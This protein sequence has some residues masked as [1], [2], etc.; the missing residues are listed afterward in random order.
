MSEGLDNKI[1][2]NVLIQLQEARKEIAKELEMKGIAEF[3][4]NVITKHI[5]ITLVS[6]IDELQFYKILPKE[7]HVSSGVQ[8]RHLG[9]DD[10]KK[11]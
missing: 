2:E 1:L 9:P 8:V 7:F 4:Q 3:Q 5:Q 10:D 11:Q 6:I